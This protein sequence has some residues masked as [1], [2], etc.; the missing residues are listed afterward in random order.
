M[1]ELLLFCTT[2][3]YLKFPKPNLCR[4][5]LESD[6]CSLQYWKVGPSQILPSSHLGHTEDALTCLWLTVCTPWLGEA[7]MEKFGFLGKEQLPRVRLTWGVLPSSP[8]P[9]LYHASSLLSLFSTLF[10]LYSL[11]FGRGRGGSAAL[12]PPPQPSLSEGFPVSLA[13]PEASC[14][15][16]PS[17]ASFGAAHRGTELPPHWSIASLHRAGSGHPSLRWASRPGTLVSSAMR[18]PCVF[19][20]AGSA[21][22]IFVTGALG[23][24][25]REQQGAYDTQT[26]SKWV[27]REQEHLC[28]VSAE[29]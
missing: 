4:H 25:D 12:S 8:A 6:H 5:P 15:H 1:P 9:F 11:F 10:F 16:A 17:S 3:I 18:N 14:R 29:A 24:A 7:G 26:I 28:T 20:E 19:W 22:G 27:L 2:K 21:F 13:L 23:A